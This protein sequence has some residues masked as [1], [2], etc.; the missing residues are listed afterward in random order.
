MARKRGRKPVKQVASSPGNDFNLAD[1]KEPQIEKQEAQFTDLDV[2]RQISAIR[3]M[4]DVE[5]EHLLT[6]LRLLRSYFTKEQLQTPLLQFFKHNYQNLSIVTC[7]ENGMMEVSEEP[8]NSLMLR[9]QDTLQTPGEDNMEAIHAMY[10][11]RAIVG[12]LA[13]VYVLQAWT[14]SNNKKKIL[15]PGSRGFPLLREPAYVRGVPSSGSALTS[16]K[17]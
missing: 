11:V 4:R 13:L 15:P 6:K 2:D 9:K 10:W 8:Y 1:E 16:S 17:A 14:K 7:G 12:L 3:A 5:I